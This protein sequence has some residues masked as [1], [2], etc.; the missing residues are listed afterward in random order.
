MP[1]LAPASAFTLD[2]LSDDDLLASTRSLVGRSNQVLAG[3]LAH[4]AEVEAR[5]IHRLRAC[6]SLYTYCVYE[7]RMSEDAACRR[8]QA[9]KHVRRFPALLEKVAAGELHL[10]GLLLL[11]PHLTEANQVE[12]LALAKHRTKKE[13]VALVRRLDPL[14]DVPARVEPLGPAPRR[15]SWANP[16]WQTFVASFNPVRNLTPGDRPRDWVPDDEA[17]DNARAAPGIADGRAAPEIA[18]APTREVEAEPSALRA[19][20]RYKVQF[21]ATEEYVKL[22]EEAQ[23][24]LAHAVKSRA[25]EEVH[26]RA[27]R[28]LVAQLKKRKYAVTESPPSQE[29]ENREHP[30]QRGAEGEAARPGGGELDPRQRGADEDPRQRGRY[31]PA[32]VRRAVWQRDG[33]RCAYVDERGV[34]CRETRGLELHHEAPYARGGPPTCANLGLRCKAHN[35]LAA[36]QD[37]GRDFM[38]TRKPPETALAR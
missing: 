26:L 24:L 15:D 13:I 25:L 28:L 1:T 7:L 37:F 6:S 12:V 34:R 29:P 32:K 31:I 36:E 4:L 22:L 23:D 8:V 10:T 11:G 16:S 5:G 17:N 21:T 38:A 30:R 2:H 19:P 27:M 20:Q 14:P 18:D 35:D 3:L 9:A 33:G